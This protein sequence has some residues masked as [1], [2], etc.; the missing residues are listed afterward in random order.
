MCEDG[1]ILNYWSFIYI[2]FVLSISNKIK[3]VFLEIHILRSHT[4]VIH[5]SFNLSINEVV[6]E[7]RI[8]STK[9]SVLVFYVKCKFL[10]TSGRRVKLAK[11]DGRPLLFIFGPLSAIRAD[12]DCQTT[13]RRF[14][15]RRRSIKLRI[16]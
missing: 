10:R 1:R 3:I 15:R 4:K 2:W 13:Q 11:F 14:A 5:K 6:F 7:G 9:T 8:C 12:K 16:K